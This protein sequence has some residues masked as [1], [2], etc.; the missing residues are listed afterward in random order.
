[1][2]LLMAVI[3]LVRRPDDI[4]P[5]FRLKSFIGHPSFKESLKHMR[6][7]PETRALIDERY[8]PDQPYNV[9]ELFKLP[10]GSLGKEY[11]RL[12]RANQLEARFYP[13]LDR[14]DDDDISYVRKRARITHDVWHLVVGFPP[15][16]IGEMGISAFYLA[17]LRTPFSAVLICVG[18]LVCTLK[19][20]HRYGDLMKAITLGWTWGNQVAP[21]FAQKWE[22]IWEHSLAEVRSHLGLPESGV[23]FSYETVDR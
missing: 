13:P 2:K 4:S 8:N 6:S 10:D 1:M 20:P 19:Q 7:Q 3:Q 14:D 15:D 21:L 22:E 16:Q 11:A 18:I 5:I 23:G 12:M 9:E 17:Q